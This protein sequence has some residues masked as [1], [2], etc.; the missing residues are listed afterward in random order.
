MKC[1]VL[2]AVA[3]FHAD[4]LQVELL[5]LK[6]QKLGAVFGVSKGGDEC[7]YTLAVDNGGGADVR[8]S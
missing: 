7:A 5:C 2:F 3:G 4:G 6:M 1:S 8:T